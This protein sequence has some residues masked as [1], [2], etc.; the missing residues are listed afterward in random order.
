MLLVQLVHK[1]ASNVV[2]DT[3]HSGDAVAKIWVQSSDFRRSSL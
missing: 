2:H 3:L 1:G